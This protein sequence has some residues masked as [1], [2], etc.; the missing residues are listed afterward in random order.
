[1]GTMYCTV[2]LIGA[3]SVDIGVWILTVL[4]AHFDIGSA[5]DIVSAH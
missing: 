3:K 2:C 1:M 4:L 5:V